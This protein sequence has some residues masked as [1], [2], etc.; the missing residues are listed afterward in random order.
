MTPPCPL[1]IAWVA[2]GAMRELDRRGGLSSQQCDAFGGQLG[3]VSAIVDHP[4]VPLLDEI[5]DAVEDGLTGVFAYEVAE[6][7]GARVAAALLDDEPIDRNALAQ[8]LVRG[9]SGDAAE[10]S[11]LILG[12]GEAP[13]ARAKGYTTVVEAFDG[14]AT[15]AAAAYE[16]QDVI[17]V[18]GPAILGQDGAFR[19]GVFGKSPR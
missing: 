16:G 13:A 15:A 6:P 11:A 7:F 1:S 14:T 2:I 8:Q 17:L 19:F 12:F 18:Q 5:A 10:P 4:S 9:V 3:F